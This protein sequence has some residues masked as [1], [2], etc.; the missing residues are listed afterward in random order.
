MTTQAPDKEQL[1]R[2]LRA[3]IT[4][5]QRLAREAIDG[6]D[7]G[8]AIAHCRSLRSLLWRA[9]NHRVAVTATDAPEPEQPA[10]LDVDDTSPR[11]GGP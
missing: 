4:N 9:S 5:T 7:L 11:N 8:I 3:E 10:G 1:A 6:L 2:Q